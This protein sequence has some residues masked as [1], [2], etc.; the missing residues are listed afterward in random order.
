MIKQIKS[1]YILKERILDFVPTNKILEIFKNSKYYQKSLQICLSTYELFYNIKQDF[2]PYDDYLDNDMLSLISHLLR[3]QKQI[4]ISTIKECYFRYLRE[5]NNISVYYDNAFLKDLLIFLQA[6]NFKNNLIIQINNLKIDLDKYIDIDINSSLINIELFFNIKWKE[7]D[8]T[9]NIPD[10]K[11]FLSK[12]VIGI[13]SSYY[14]KKMRFLEPININDKEH[15]ELYDYL[16]VSF[17]NCVF[18]IQCNYIPDQNFWKKLDRFHQLKVIIQNNEKE[19]EIKENKNHYSYVPYTNTQLTLINKCF[20]SIQNISDLCINYDRKRINLTDKYINDISIQK[21]EKIIFEDFEYEYRKKYFGELNGLIELILIQKIFKNTPFPISISDKLRSLLVLELVKVNILEDQ[22]VSVIKNNPL[23]EVFE[24]KKN[25][26]GY[27]YEIKLASALSGLNYLKILSTQFFW[28]KTNLKSN[29][30]FK[31]FHVEE[32]QFFKFLKSD[33]IKYLN[34]LNESNINIHTIENN[35]PNLIRL[36]IEVSNLITYDIKEKNINFDNSKYI[37]SKYKNRIIIHDNNN[38]INN[39]GENNIFKKLRFLNLFKV[40][41]FGSFFKKLANLNNLE[42]LTIINFDKRLFDSFTKFSKDMDNVINL[43]VIPD[44]GEKMTS[45]ESEPFIKNIHR[46]KNL[47]LINIGLFTIDAYLINILYEELKKL[48]ELEQVKI[49]VELIFESN[50]VILEE[51][52]KS[53]KNENKL[54]DTKIIYKEK[55]NKIW[56]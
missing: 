18:N 20:A 42:N 23:L 21:P 38:I 26:S 47:K 31:D 24:I 40:L 17:P 53:L 5:Q 11:N 33:S 28:Y 9:N 36:S 39:S 4:S 56:I 29:E 3:L 27:V 10:I 2:E 54:L 41:N 30:L 48:K 49:T 55:K 15:I 46:F 51:K 50:K 7:K 8:K 34:I 25:F 6:R 37:S 13:N 32:N 45:K 19:N 1:L 14:I 52:I 35:L 43:T 12:K 22:L 16:L 44:Y